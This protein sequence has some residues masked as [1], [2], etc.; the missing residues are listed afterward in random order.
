[1]EILPEQLANW[2]LRY[3]LCSRTRRSRGADSSAAMFSKAGSGS[4]RVER[5]GYRL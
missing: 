3:R 5:G 2:R 1:M 4:M